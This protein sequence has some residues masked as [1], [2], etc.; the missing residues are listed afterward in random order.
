MDPDLGL[1]V[2]VSLR[3]VLVLP[4]VVSNTILV[5]V[6]AVLVKDVARVV[7]TVITSEDIVPNSTTSDSIHHSSGSLS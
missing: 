5:L 3:S 6:V 4:L 2:Q 1:R 7:T